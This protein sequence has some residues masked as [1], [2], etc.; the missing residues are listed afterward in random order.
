MEAAL[1]EYR[2]FAEAGSMRKGLLAARIA[3][4]TLL[5]IAGFVPA[6]SRIATPSDSE[7][8]GG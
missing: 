6:I 4:L 2:R 7:F 5:A 3:G 1:R 8:S